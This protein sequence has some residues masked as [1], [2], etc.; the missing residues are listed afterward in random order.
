M[1]KDISDFMNLETKENE[2]KVVIATP[3]PK[4]IVKYIN[5]CEIVFVKNDTDVY[6]SKVINEYDYK[7][8]FEVNDSGECN[9]QI[10]RNEFFFGAQFEKIIKKIFFYIK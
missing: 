8:H 4:K 1:L 5:E 7:L 6:G 2:I 10:H 3:S 9:I